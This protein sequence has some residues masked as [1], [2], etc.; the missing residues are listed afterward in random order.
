M[1]ASA[2]LNA[3]LEAALNVEF[4]VADNLREQM[5]EAIAELNCMTMRPVPSITHDDD[6]FRSENEEDKDITEKDSQKSSDSFHVDELDIAA[7]ETIAY[8]GG[9]PAV[10][11]TCFPS[12]HSNVNSKVNPVHTVA[13]TKLSYLNHAELLRK[14]SGI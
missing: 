1:D 11:F 7:S 12:N 4:V 3:K 6:S 14:Y 5:Y 8:E 2:A 9:E 10:K 13:S